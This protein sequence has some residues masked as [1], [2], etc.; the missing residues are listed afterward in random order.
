MRQIAVIRKC[1]EEQKNIILESIEDQDQLVFFDNEQEFLESDI[2]GEIEVIF[3]EPEFSTIQKMKTLRWI[4]MA[5]AGAN[6]YTSIKNFPKNITVTGAS[7]AYGCVISEYIVS[8]ILT[9]YKSLIP[10]RKLIES[11]QWKMI[12][13]DDTLEGKRVLILGTGN[14]GEETAKKMQCF[15]TEVIGIC[16]TP[17]SEQQLFDEVYTIERLD[18]QLTKADVV[19]VTLPG[20]EETRKLFDAER[21]KKM[22]SNAIFVNVGRG[23]IVD[24]DALT[25]AILNGHL[26]G[27]VLDVTDPEPL[28]ENHLLR[29]MEN[30]I[31]T[32][33]ISGI[34]WGDNNRTK[35]RILE[36]FCD[37]LKKDSQGERKNNIID[38]NKGY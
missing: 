9:L 7:G 14:I 22:K 20:T 36:I 17:R 19:I 29:K 11:G 4:Q 23:F 35:R 3:G 25:D 6:K 27:A 16:R 28:P 31:L 26:R 24:T 18:E 38:F 13:G 8:G 21:I 1:S 37:N 15:G 12:E 30:V 33:H 32:P 5:W 10:Y 34:S 2:I